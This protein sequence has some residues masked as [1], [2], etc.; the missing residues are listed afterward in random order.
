MMTIPAAESFHT[1]IVGWPMAPR[2]TIMD[3]GTDTYSATLKRRP[4]CLVEA[5]GTIRFFCLESQCLILL[6]RNGA[7]F[8]INEKIAR[9]EQCPKLQL[10]E[11]TTGLVTVEF[12]AT[13]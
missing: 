4:T 7:V 10:S 3:I 5:A 2:R 6:E 8:S 1:V 9:S 12:S 11:D 13:T